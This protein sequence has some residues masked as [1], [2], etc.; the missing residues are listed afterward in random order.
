VFRK[1]LGFHKSLASAIGA[2]CKIRML[3]SISIKCLDN[4]LGFDCHFVDGAKSE[5]DDSFGVSKRPACIGGRPYMPRI[6]AGSRI[7]MAYSRRQALVN[8]R[9]GKATVAHTFVS[10]TPTCKR[11][12]NFHFDIG[13]LGGLDLSSDAAKSRD[14][15]EA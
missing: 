12:P 9:S 3:G 13:I 8:N 2:A 10:A 4:R 14:I 6:R 1:T 15:F 5:V 7:A 11:H